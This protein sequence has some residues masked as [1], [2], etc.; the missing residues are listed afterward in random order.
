MVGGIQPAV[1]A[2]VEAILKKPGGGRSPSAGHPGRHR[3]PGSAPAP[4]GRVRDRWTG[5]RQPSGQPARH[6]LGRRSGT[7]RCRHLGDRLREH[8]VCRGV[9]GAGGG[10]HRQARQPDGP[11]GLHQERR[12]DRTGGCP[13]RR[14]H[15]AGARRAAGRRAA[16]EAALQASRA[17]PGAGRRSGGPGVDRVSGEPR[18][19]AALWRPGAPPGV[20]H[21]ARQRP[22]YDRHRAGHR[23]PV[24]RRA[25]GSLRPPA[26]NLG[27][28]SGRAGREAG[29]RPR[30]AGRDRDSGWRGP[31]RDHS[32]SSPGRAASRSCSSDIPSVPESGR[33][34]GAAPWTNSFAVPGEWTCGSFR[35]NR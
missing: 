20:H 26:A 22:R 6:P 9:A 21:A 16:P 23:R 1:P 31:Y 18:N 4:S 14:S 35:N 29:D 11:G 5:L 24:S 28:G 25:H 32:A 13:S 17:D 2:D 15:R 19:R 8:P 3:S 7:H 10:H 33:A 34:C 27:G 12:R 30:G